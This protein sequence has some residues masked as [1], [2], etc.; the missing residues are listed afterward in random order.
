VAIAAVL[1]LLTALTAEATPAH[2]PVAP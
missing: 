1:G 2:E